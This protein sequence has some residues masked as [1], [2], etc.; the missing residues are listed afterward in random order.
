[1]SGGRSFGAQRFEGPRWKG[2]P[3][4]EARDSVDR[5][6]DAAMTEQNP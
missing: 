5:A 2:E 3:E 6:L 1:M 4:D